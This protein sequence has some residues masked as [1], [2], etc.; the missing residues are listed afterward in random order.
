MCCTP[1]SLVTKKMLQC[2]HIRATKLL[3][4]QIDLRGSVKI[5]GSVHTDFPYAPGSNVAREWE[6]K[7]TYFNGKS[8]YQRKTRYGTDPTGMHSYYAVPIC[9][10]FV[11]DRKKTQPEYSSVELSAATC[12]SLC[13]IEVAVEVHIL[14]QHVICAGEN[15]IVSTK[16]TIPPEEWKKVEK[17]AHWLRWNNKACGG[18]NSRHVYANPKIERRVRIS[19][20]KAKK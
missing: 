15:Q 11:F 9:E 19:K 4:L 1:N 16:F 3:Y 13:T 12:L 10:P 5:R 8:F 20:R 2:K 17:V 18:K 14:P 6:G 7:T